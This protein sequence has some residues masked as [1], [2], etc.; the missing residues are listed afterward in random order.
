M[1]GDVRAFLP[2]LVPDSFFHC[3]FYRCSLLTPTTT[4]KLTHSSLDRLSVIQHAQLSLQNV[5]SLMNTFSV[6]VHITNLVSVD[7][8]S[9]E[10]TG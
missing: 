10:L 3:D 9:S 4:N 5:H 8:T 7:L 2:T 6:N 1:T